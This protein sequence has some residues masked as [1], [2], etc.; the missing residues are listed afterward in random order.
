[1][2]QFNENNQTFI[3]STENTC[4]AFK[5]AHNKYP[6][7]LYYGKR[8]DLDITYCEEATNFSVIPS[9]EEIFS[10]D[11]AMLEFS[12][13]GIGDYRTTSIKITGKCNN[14]DSCFIYCG[15]KIMDG[16]I[17]IDGLPYA[18]NGSGIETLEIKL[19][20]KIL[21][22]NLYL[23][24]TV[25]PNCDVIVRSAK[26][27]NLGASEVF[28]ENCA[29]VC[30]DLKGS[31]FDV[32]SLSGCY[33]KEM[34]RNRT[35]LFFGSQKVFSRRG[36]TSHNFNSF[37]AICEKTANY[38]KG[39]VYA[40][41]L[42]YSGDFVTEAETSYVS[43]AKS[44][45]T[46][47]RIQTGINSE[48]FSYKLGYNEVFHSPQGIITY[49]GNGFNGISDNFHKFIKNYILPRNSSVNPIVLNTWEGCFFDIDEKKLLGFA[50]ECAEI[51]IDTLVVDDGWFGHRNNDKSSL[52]DWFSNDEKFPDGIC[53]FAEKVR[54]CGLNFG[55]WIE[56]EMISVDSELFKRKPEWVLGNPNRNLSFG[57]NQL[58][59]DMANPAVI[60]YLKD[61]LGKLFR[62][63][64]VSYIKWDMNRNLSEV[65]SVYLPC[66]RQKETSFRYM[67]GVYSLL[68]WFKKEFSEITLETC[69]GGGGRYDLGMMCFSSMIWCSDNTSPK[70]R[71]Y[72]QNGALIA[73]P[74]CVMS[75][76]IS[77]PNGICDDIDEL[78][79]RYAVSVQGQLGFEMDISKVSKETKNLIKE[80]IIDYKQIRD[81]ISNGQ[82][83]VLLSP[84]ETE[85]SAFS[86]KSEKEIFVDMVRV[87][88][89]NV[90]ST[91]LKLLNAE[92]NATYVEH[93]SGAKVSGK[94]LID[95]IKVETGTDE[96]FNLLLHYIK[97]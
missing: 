56:P 61:V 81:V 4:Y 15:Y 77:N 42:L 5:I 86:Y 7:H 18:K 60:D 80:L 71:V 94:S 52:G 75:A 1:M 36:A 47:T 58:V 90:T 6:V 25:Y 21:S 50:R 51:G 72:I 87:G 16:N 68:Q 63:T 89:P 35:P 29:S 53:E 39:N 97:D 95:G 14:G 22:C 83:S 49:S 13:F 66:D 24:Y 74:S 91:T 8:E 10:L 32:I 93:Y 92:P 46:L 38:D 34:Q 62:E 31:D 45:Y 85:F 57:R 11:A 76:H 40:V 23:Y 12:G 19:Y 65:G 27:E 33:A 30:L 28:I 84:N 79:Y 44:E 55:L 54:A 26:V 9:G 37:M 59:L 96:R 20:D 41:N 88:Q 3:L 17:R 67:Q 64:K 43:L 48:N 82:Y 78:K 70:N 69:S 73:Y 2:I